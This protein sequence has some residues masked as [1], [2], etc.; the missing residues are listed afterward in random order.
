M[1]EATER[2][3]A[4]TSHSDIPVVPSEGSSV[5][6]QFKRGQTVR[7]ETI[8]AGVRVKRRGTVVRT[9]DSGK[10]LRVEVQT[11]DGERFRAHLSVVKA[12]AQTA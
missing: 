2:D 4:L 12:V 8:G 7:F 10:G 5:A 6:N 1:C 9:V 11:K 3:I